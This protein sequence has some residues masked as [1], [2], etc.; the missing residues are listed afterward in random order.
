VQTNKINTKSKQQIDTKPIF[1][2]QDGFDELLMSRIEKADKRI[3]VIS[4]EEGF[5]R[6]NA[7]LKKQWDTR[8][9]K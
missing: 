8:H 1:E 3:G 5:A 2:N 4:L 7:N 6:V 9:G